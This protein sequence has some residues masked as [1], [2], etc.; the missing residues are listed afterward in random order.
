MLV[1]ETM[2]SPAPPDS[3]D[4]FRCVR[5]SLIPQPVEAEYEERT[6]T[7]KQKNILFEVRLNGMMVLTAVMAVSHIQINS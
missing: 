2:G 5:T 3:W 4:S 6:P 7:E 1:V